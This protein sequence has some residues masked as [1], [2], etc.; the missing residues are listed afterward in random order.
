VPAHVIVHFELEHHTLRGKATRSAVT[1]RLKRLAADHDG[2][3]SLTPSDP[4]T[5]PA[6]MA[7]I[8]VPDM[9]RATALAD[10]LRELDGVEAAYPKPGEELP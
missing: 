2:H 1:D 7:T 9:D 10:A 8:T 3:L 5:S 6:P 4:G